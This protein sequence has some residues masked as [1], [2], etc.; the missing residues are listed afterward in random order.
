M[1]ENSIADAFIHIQMVLYMICN[2]KEENCSRATH[3]STWQEEL[4]PYK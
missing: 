3:Y 4:N 2:V 1:Y